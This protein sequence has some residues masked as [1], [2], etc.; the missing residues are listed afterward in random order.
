MVKKNE[1]VE[2]FV[3][4]LE[5]ELNKWQLYKCDS[6]GHLVNTLYE[7]YDDWVVLEQFYLDEQ[8][9]ITFP[10]GVEQIQ[11]NSEGFKKL[12]VILEEGKIKFLTTHTRT[13]RKETLHF[14]RNWF[15]VP[16][17]DKEKL[18]QAIEKIKAVLDP[19][20]NDELTFLY[21]IDDGN[22]YYLITTTRPDRLVANNNSAYDM[23][24]E[25]K[26]RADYA[27][28]LLEIEDAIYQL[29][30]ERKR[31]KAAL[32]RNNFSLISSRNRF[33]K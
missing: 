15:S 5:K 23:L 24:L 30:Q 4:L 25:R 28:E 18:N 33:L 3:E 7:V 27:L 22:L 21:T 8:G 13:G 19:A 26:Q 6:K 17:V 14:S 29:S 1:A 31:I 12:N 16:S 9:S 2:V 10:I 20:D 11:S 32:D